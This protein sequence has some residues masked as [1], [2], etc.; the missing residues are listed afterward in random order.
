MTDPFAYRT[1]TLTALNNATK[2]TGLWTCFPGVIRSNK[3]NAKT[4]PY[5]WNPQMTNLDLSSDFYVEWSADNDFRSGEIYHI[6]RNWAGGA[7][8]PWS[9]ARFFITNARIPIE[10]CF[11]HRRLDC[12]VSNTALAPKPEQLARLLFE[13]LRSRGLIDEPAWLNWYVAKEQ[14]GARFGEVFDPD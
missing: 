6:K 1:S 10:G 13:V 12:F 5:I 11:P 8:V 14:G 3:T 4:A 2:R 7:P 9:V